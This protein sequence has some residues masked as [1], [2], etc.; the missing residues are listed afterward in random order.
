[1]MEH[2]EGDEAVG[3]GEAAAAAPEVEDPNAAAEEAEDDGEEQDDESLYA[4]D[5][6]K[7]WTQRVKAKTAATVPVAPKTTSGFK[8]VKKSVV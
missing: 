8:R 5:V 2:S 4:R 6:I 7:P 1:M 3:D